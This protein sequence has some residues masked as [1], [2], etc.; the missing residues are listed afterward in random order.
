MHCFQTDLCLH[1]YRYETRHSYTA[2]ACLD[3]EYSRFPTE[4]EWCVRLFSEL[5]KDPNYAAGFQD[6]D[7]VLKL[8]PPPGIMGY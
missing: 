7:Q 8:V 5:L 6:C 3:Q 2:D 4:A 1:G